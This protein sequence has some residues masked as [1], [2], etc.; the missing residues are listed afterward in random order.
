MQDVAA[1]KAT[2]T[3]GGLFSAAGV[4]AFGGITG[5]VGAGG[6]D[7]HAADQQRKSRKR[8]RPGTGLARRSG[9]LMHRECSTAGEEQ[10]SVPDAARLRV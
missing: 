5:A 3:A 9:G 10:I 6:V 1:G 7:P 8:I 2:V 4:S